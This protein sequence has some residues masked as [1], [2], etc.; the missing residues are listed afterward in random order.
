MELIVVLAIITMLVGIGLGAYIRLS[1]ERTFEGH[2]TSVAELLSLG[3]VI[4]QRTNSPVMVQC[5]PYENSVRVV[6][7]T[8]ITLFRFED[9]SGGTVTGTGGME[10]LIKNAQ[11]VAGYIGMGLEFGTQ[12]GLKCS[13]SYVEFSS[14][15]LLSP[16]GGLLIEAWIY[17]GDFNGERFKQLL[18]KTSEDE[19]ENKTKTKEKDTFKKR[20]LEEHR[21]YIVELREAY[22]LRLTESYAL[23]FGIVPEETAYPF[24]TR[25]GVIKANMWNHIV[26]RYEVDDLRIYV[27]GVNVSVFWVSDEYRMIPLYKMKESQ[28]ELTMPKRIPE[29]DQPFYISAPGDSFYGVIDEVRIGAIAPVEEYVIPSS[30]HLMGT[31][32]RIYFNAKGELDPYYHSSDEVVLLTDRFG[33]KPPPEEKGGF[34]EGGSLNAPPTPEQAEELKKEEEKQETDDRDSR[35]AILRVSASG[36][37]SLSFMRWSEYFGGGKD[38]E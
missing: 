17:P 29:T 21:F 7:E 16:P 4:S 30:V 14:N 38:E 5:D 27:N 31:K 6:R 23:E 36:E 28:R 1:A 2:A 19:K 3:K 13:N 25:N 10:G 37:V 24:R 32:K 34:S 20:Y 33:Y 26:V 15:Y 22:Y 35:M 11:S 18:G 9:V 8:T 12:E